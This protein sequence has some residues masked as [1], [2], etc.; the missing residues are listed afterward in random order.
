MTQLLWDRGSIK[1]SEKFP[2]RMSHHHDSNLRKIQT[3]KIRKT[4]SRQQNYAR[5]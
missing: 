3:F 1:E 4:Y 2:Y 5:I